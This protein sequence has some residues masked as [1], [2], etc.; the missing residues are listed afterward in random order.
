MRDQLVEERVVTGAWGH[1]GCRM[2]VSWRV[3]KGGRGGS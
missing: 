2:A 1:G 3:E